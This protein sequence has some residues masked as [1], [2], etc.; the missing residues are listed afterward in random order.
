[1][2][3]LTKHQFTLLTKLA[4]SKVKTYCTVAN[5]NGEETEFNETLRLVNLKLLIDIS[6][7]YPDVVKKYSTNGDDAAVT[8]LTHRGQWMFERVKWDKWVN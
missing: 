2:D 4:N 3:T 5:A 7:R 8:A 1:M 6:D